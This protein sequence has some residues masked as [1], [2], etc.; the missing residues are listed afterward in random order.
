MSSKC[1]QLLEPA[2]DDTIQCLFFSPKLGSDVSVWEDLCQQLNNSIKSI[3]KDYI[4]H[5]DEFQI[6]NPIIEDSVTGK[7]THTFIVLI[8]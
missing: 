4:W 6:Y 7:H 2:N 8:L 3:T 5:Q 1:K